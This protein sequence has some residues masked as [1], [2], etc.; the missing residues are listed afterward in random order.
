WLLRTSPFAPQPSA[1]SKGDDAPPRYDK[2]RYRF[3]RTKRHM[4][5][6]YPFVGD[7]RFAHPACGGDFA[8]AVP[9]RVEFETATEA[10]KFGVDEFDCLFCL[11]C[12]SHLER[13]V[14]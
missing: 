2:I 8:T 9:L 14:P 11:R 5:H 4:G 3:A 6:V 12:R 1:R 7:L 13:F 10:L